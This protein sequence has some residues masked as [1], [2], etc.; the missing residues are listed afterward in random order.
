MTRKWI[1]QEVV[2]KKGAGLGNWNQRRGWVQ[3]DF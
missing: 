2:Y 3:V 1:E